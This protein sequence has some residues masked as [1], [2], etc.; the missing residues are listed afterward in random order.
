MIRKELAEKIQRR[1][2][3]GLA[4]DDTDIS[5]ELINVHITDAI[6]LMAK[7]NYSD[8][9]E[10]E[11]IEGLADGFYSTFKNI[12][13][14]KDEDLGLYY[15]DLPQAPYGIA[16]GHDITNFS[17]TGFTSGSQQALR[18][19]GSDLA[20]MEQQRYVPKRIYYFLDGKKA[21]LKT[22]YVLDNKKV[23][24]RMA[25]PSENAD[26]DSEL[27]V[28][29]EYIP[30]IINYVISILVPEEQS[31]KDISNDGLNIK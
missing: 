13:I 31:P 6:A 19:K 30:D 25:S 12:P 16:R 1:V 14:S 21:W 4:T 17:V 27:N 29:L 7:K 24:I 11:G 3:G 28:P 15:C 9:I 5:L 18:I 20:L 2:V 22:E 10:L 8:S 23:R 26:L